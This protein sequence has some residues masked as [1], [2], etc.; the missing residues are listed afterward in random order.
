ME[1]GGSAL[2]ILT[3]KPTGNIPL[4]RPRRTW[5]ENIRMDLRERVFNMSNWFYSAQG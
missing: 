4:G 3:G 1:E 5:E 2:K